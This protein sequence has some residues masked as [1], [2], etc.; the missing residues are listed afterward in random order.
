MFLKSCKPEWTKEHIE[1]EWL[2]ILGEMFPG[3][4]VKSLTPADWAV[5]MS[6]APSKIVPF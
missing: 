1:G 2:R 6:E 4:D 5:V 3:K